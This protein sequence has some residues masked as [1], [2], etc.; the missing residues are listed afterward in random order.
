MS[1]SNTASTSRN[2]Q[3]EAPDA[4][5]LVAQ[6][7]NLL[8]ALERIQAQAWTQAPDG[9]PGFLNPQTGMA[10]QIAATQF[11]ESLS[12]T[13]LR[14]IASYLQANVEKNAGLQSCLGVIVQ[15]AQYFGARDF[16]RAF[17]CAWQ[18]YR[19]IA[20][21]RLTDPQLPPLQFSV[22]MQDSGSQAAGAS[23][24]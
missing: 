12:A 14:S 21:V 19:T 11:V 5:D 9:I 13:V 15:A 22:G 6:L 7:R 10:D 20:H 16:A 1:E 17:D 18:A 2:P 8:P 3:H 24:H 4:S 23:I